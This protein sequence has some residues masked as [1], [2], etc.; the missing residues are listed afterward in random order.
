MLQQVRYAFAFVLPL[1][2]V[3]ACKPKGDAAPIS[4]SPAEAPGQATAVG[5]AKIAPLSFAPIAKKADP[6]VVTIYTVGED[7]RH[8]GRSKGLGS[9]F[10]V[11]EA[12]NNATLSTPCA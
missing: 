5:D 4:A 10:I 11:D 1:A 12:S 6:S 8:R 2:L 7:P 9:G 3:P